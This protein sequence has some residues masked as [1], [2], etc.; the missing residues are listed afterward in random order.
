[1]EEKRTNGQKDY[2][3][4]L[5]ISPDSSSGDFVSRD[6]QILPELPEVFVYVLRF[7]VDSVVG[8]GLEI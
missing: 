1:M 6:Y 5:Q 2:G 4:P 3:P 7:S 8:Y